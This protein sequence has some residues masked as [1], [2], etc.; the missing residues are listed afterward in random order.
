MRICSRYE[1]FLRE[2][3]RRVKDNES[4]RTTDKVRERERERW[5]KIGERRRV[6]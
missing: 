5:G 2:K 4:V 6:F 3:D 1:K